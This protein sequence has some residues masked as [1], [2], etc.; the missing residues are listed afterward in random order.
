MSLHV[1]LLAASTIAGVLAVV[2]LM[3]GDN[4]VPRPRSIGHP[5]AWARLAG[6]GAAALAVVAAS[7]WL[8][9]ALVVAVGC[10]HAIGAWQRRDAGGVSDLERSPTRLPACWRWRRARRRSGH[11]F[12]G[13]RPD[14][15]VRIRP[16]CSAAS[17]TT[18]TTHWA[19]SWPPDC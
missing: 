5:G 1:A 10:W 15:V 6:A 4:A 8:V 13:W 12:V 3:A 16:S 17:P 19:T 18:S 11:R 7:G 2:V 9:A 14:S